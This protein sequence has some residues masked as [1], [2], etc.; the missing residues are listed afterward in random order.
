[1]TSKN[2]KYIF[3]KFILLLSLSDYKTFVWNNF[4]LKSSDFQIFIKNKIGQF[5]IY[6]IKFN[7]CKNFEKLIQK[8]KM[9]RNINNINYLQKFTCWNFK[10]SKI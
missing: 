9:F 10:V 4:F 2:I 1:V 8:Y 5:C 7:T 3:F 6:L